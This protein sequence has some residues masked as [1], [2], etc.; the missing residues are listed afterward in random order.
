M[1]E[2]VIYY[3]W[4]GGWGVGGGWGCWDG[5]WYGHAE[6]FITIMP[7][8]EEDIFRST[9]PTKRNRTLTIFLFLFRIPYI[10]EEKK[11]SEP[12]GKANFGRTGATEITTPPTEFILALPV[13]E[14][15]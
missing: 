7:I 5:G 13:R 10:S 3:M 8:P 1:A 6:G 2:Y 4:T 9:R 15:I 14:K 12:D 11:G